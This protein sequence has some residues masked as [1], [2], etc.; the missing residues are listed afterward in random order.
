MSLAVLKEGRGGRALKRTLC[1]GQAVRHPRV[2]LNRHAQSAGDGFKRGL[3]DVVRVE[4]MHQIDVQGDATM[5]RK[6]LKEFAHKFGV[7]RA[8][9]VGREINVP[10][11]KWPRRQVQR[12][13]HLGVIHRQS[14][15]AVAANALFVTDRFDQSLTNGDARVLD[16]VVIVN[17][18]VALGADRHVNQRV[19][20]Q[21]IE[22]VVKKADA[23]LVVVDTGPVEIDLD[24][25]LGFRRVAG[26]GGLAHGH[27]LVCLGC[28]YA[29]V[30]G[31]ANKLRAARGFASKNV[32]SWPIQGLRPAND[33]I[34]VKKSLF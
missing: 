19:T 25:D 4:S 7:E 24:R 28:L 6:R 27:V 34:L 26:D 1:G 5:G 33:A 16:R 22:H 12:G 21:L 23:G 30:A 14:K 15:V 3:G 2:D 9:F 11:Q 20:R 29:R 18:G 13:G 31:F 10:N 32:L 17:V 8:D